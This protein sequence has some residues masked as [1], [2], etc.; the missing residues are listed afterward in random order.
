MEVAEYETTRQNFDKAF[1]RVD[2]REYLPATSAAADQ[3]FDAT[4]HG[5]YKLY[6][7]TGPDDRGS[8]K[9][10]GC[11]GYGDSHGYGYGMGMGTVMNPHGFCG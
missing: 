10:Q 11:R 4:E 9:L 3:T 6:G 8:N 1:E 7:T 5:D 2:S